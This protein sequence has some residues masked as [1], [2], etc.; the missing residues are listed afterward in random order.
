[1]F[2]QDCQTINCNVMSCAYNEQGQHCSLKSI[3]VCPCCGGDTAKAADESMCA[4][5]QAK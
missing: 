5:Y 1:M 2:K 3:Q 4:S